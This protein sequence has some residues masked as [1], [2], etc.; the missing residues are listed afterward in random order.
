MKA[1]DWISVEDRLPD[2]THNE[3]F[4]EYSD[5]VIICLNGC[6]I[7]VAVLVSDKYNKTKYFLSSIGRYTYPIGIVTHWQEIVLPKKEKE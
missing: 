4:A 7:V 3:S 2:T 6:E 5:E 1:S